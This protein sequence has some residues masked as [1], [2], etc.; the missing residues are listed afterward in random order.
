[1][2]TLLGIALIWIS[3]LAGSECCLARIEI[4]GI[5]KSVSGEVFISGPQKT[6][7]ALPNMKIA[8]GERIR[9]GK[10]S[11]VGIIFED[12]TVIALGPNSDITIESFLFNPIDQEFSFVAKLIRGTFSFITGQIAKLAPEKVILATPDATLGVRGTKFLV[13]ID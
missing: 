1:M 12:D 2:K 8:Q 13:Q 9:T 4:V 3:I 7:Q 6:V 11:S 10:E 5:I